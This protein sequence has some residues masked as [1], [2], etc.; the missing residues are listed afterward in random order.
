MAE[1]LIGVN[2]FYSSTDS[3][4]VEGQLPEEHIN[5]CYYLL[6]EYPIHWAAVMLNVLEA[7]KKRKLCPF[8]WTAAMLN[9][10]EATKKR[11]LDELEWC[12]EE[13]SE[14]EV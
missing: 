11:K 8:H 10:S 7:P 4:A 3:P 14:T 1:L 13:E 6:R 12:G 2:R 9:A 5:A